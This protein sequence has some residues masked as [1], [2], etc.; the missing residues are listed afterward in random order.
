MSLGSAG[1]SESRF[2]AYV[3]ALV[4][5]TGHMDRAGPLGDDLLGPSD[6]ALVTR[7]PRCP[8]CADLS[9]RRAAEEFMT[10]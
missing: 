8:C 5:V 10:E 7:L 9:A 6:V 3:E 1:D 4:S 2:A